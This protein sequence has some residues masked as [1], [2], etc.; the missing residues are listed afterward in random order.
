[1]PQKTEYLN[2]DVLDAIKELAQK[3]KFLY[4]VG[5]PEQIQKLEDLGIAKYFVGGLQKTEVENQSGNQK[6]DSEKELDL[7]SFVKRFRINPENSSY[8]CLNNETKP[9][10]KK[11]GLNIIFGEKEENQEIGES[12]KVDKNQKHD[13]IEDYNQTAVQTEKDNTIQAKKP[14][15][16][17]N[18]LELGIWKLEIKG[19]R[20][21]LNS[22]LDVNFENTTFE[23]T[24]DKG[25]NYLEQNFEEE[26]EEESDDI[27]Q[28]VSALE[29]DVEGFEDEDWDDI[30]L[31]RELE[32]NQTE[33]SKIDHENF[34]DVLEF[35]KVLGKDKN[36]PKKDLDNS[37]VL[38]QDGH[39][40]I[41]SWL[42]KVEYGRISRLPKVP[43]IIFVGKPNVG[44]SSLFNA[45]AGQNIQ[46]VSDIAGTT[47][48][49]ND[50]LIE[51]DI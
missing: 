13:K 48:S 23:N 32:N 6:N 20:S 8:I 31:E 49:V 16:V 44:K 15:Y 18:A 39:S 2:P 9:K 10:I 38:A 33:N 3:N 51:V 41:L 29:E 22:N 24:E 34:D 37:Q 5:S 17:D 30:Y 7:S 40:E 46:I 50:T 45:L 42:E 21:I 4:Y 11:K 36:Q 28:E 25:S 47:L 26:V 43:K 14:I 27:L 12:E 35:R 19:M 1:M